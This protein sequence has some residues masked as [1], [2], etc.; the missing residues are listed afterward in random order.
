MTGHIGS[1]R[2]APIWGGLLALAIVLIDRLSK[3]WI[4]EGLGLQ[5]GE[6]VPVLPVFSLTFV[7]NEGISLGLFKQGTETGRHILIAMTGAISLVLLVWLVRLRAPLEA[8]AVGAILGGA[9]GNIWDRI[10][11]GAVADFLHVHVGGWSFYIF[12][13][14]DA[15]ISLGVIALLL[16]GI[17]RPK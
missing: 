4:L 11:Y 15:A 12:N 1:S 2:R 16:A 13:I 8:L 6:S 5:P 3:L 10:R 9:V 7:W 17:S 14:A